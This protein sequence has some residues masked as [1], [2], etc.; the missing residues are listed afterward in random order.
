ML[1]E[2]CVIAYTAYAMLSIAKHCIGGIFHNVLNLV[3]CKVEKFKTIIIFS[4]MRC[5]LCSCGYKC[6]VR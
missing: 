2:T 5:M 3:R 4:I 6:Y 1:L